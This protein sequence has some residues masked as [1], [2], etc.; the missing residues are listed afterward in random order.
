MTM[1]PRLSS[2]CEPA[3]RDGSVGETGF[4][5]KVQLAVVLGVLTSVMVVVAQ[6][7]FG[8]EVTLDGL[9]YFQWARDIGS[10]NFKPHYTPPLYPMLLAVVHGFSGLS[11]E[12]V[13]T[14]VNA[15]ALGTTVGVVGAWVALRGASP[16]LTAWTGLLCATS[17]LADL[18]SRALTDA[19]FVALTTL[20]LIALDGFL[21]GSR[22]K[23]LC[24]ALAT[25]AAGSAGITRAGV[26]LPLIGTIALFVFVCGTSSWRRRLSH[27]AAVAACAVLPATAWTLY[28]WVG[29]KVSPFSTH[30][31][32]S[33]AA[34]QRVLELL[35]TWLFTPT[36]TE[37]LEDG[38]A[39]LAGFADVAWLPFSQNVK[40]AFLC[41]LGFLLIALLVA[42]RR[43]L[44]AAVARTHALIATFLV[45]YAG[46]LF[47][48]LWSTDMPFT[49]RFLMPLYA[50]G[51]VMVALVLRGVFAK[52]RE[53][54]KDAR[55]SR[56]PRTRVF[57]AAGWC[58]VLGG[59][60]ACQG[61]K[62]QQ[63]IVDTYNDARTHFAE[64]RGFS[65]RRW[66]QSETIGFLRETVAP[67]ALIVTEEATA[68]NWALRRLKRRPRV[69][70]PIGS[71]REIRQRL[72]KKKLRPQRPD[73][74]TYV[75][76][77][78]DL[79]QPGLYASDERPRRL[80]DWIGTP[81]LRVLRAFRDGVVFKLEPVSI[82]GATSVLDASSLKNAILAGVLNGG[83]R[84]YSGGA[85]DVY[86]NN[87]YQGYRIGGQLVYSFRDCG[88]L[89]PPRSVFLHIVPVDLADLPADR[90]RSGF[91]NL[92]HQFTEGRRYIYPACLAIVDLPR[93]RL[94]SIRTGQW[95]GKTTDWEVEIAL[96]PA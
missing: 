84:I 90:V 16:L 10:G 77:F 35:L 87:L 22:R 7:R 31:L 95:D 29:G 80:L 12:W 4:G 6:A 42:T 74:E 44:L 63:Q 2:T 55:A 78:H 52:T 37:H 62:I 83:R 3:R 81:G 14:S 61:V 36:P 67:T 11:M 45:T 58:G 24:L 17:T 88:R 51:L 56:K 69:W 25:V 70:R 9:F 96:G 40:A 59:I 28:A 94:K 89:P 18:A 82:N 30:P 66:Q 72:A 68:V 5:K 50:P 57:A 79:R 48:C 33:A 49:K 41:V 76:W 15:L 34:Y 47:V 39:K 75:V 26:S 27:A 53:S 21:G 85:F 38:I 92:D 32:D 60:A 19:C 13:A 1:A 43:N 86:R 23:R 54:I 8:A 65:A 93:Y 20:S 91:D 73:G 71:V 64:G 46:W